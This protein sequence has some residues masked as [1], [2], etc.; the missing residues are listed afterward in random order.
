MRKRVMMLTDSNQGELLQ[1]VYVP[2]DILELPLSVTEDGSISIP[3]GIPWASTRIQAENLWQRSKP[4]FSG[5]F[6]VIVQQQWPSLV[7]IIV[8]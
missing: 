5:P 7:F 6:Y 4:L 3:R 1:N 8:A 2:E